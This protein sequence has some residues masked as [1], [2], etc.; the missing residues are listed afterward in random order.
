MKQKRPQQETPNHKF[1]VSS[2]SS[3]SRPC[4][5]FRQFC[6]KL[7]K[8]IIG[9]TFGLLK[10]PLRMTHC[11]WTHWLARWSPPQQIPLSWQIAFHSKFFLC[12]IGH[13]SLFSLITH[14]RNWGWKGL[15]WL[16]RNTVFARKRLLSEKKHPSNNELGGSVLLPQKLL[17]VF[18][19]T[20]TQTNAPSRPE[21]IRTCGT[22]YWTKKSNADSVKL[23]SKDRSRV[24][25][26]AGITQR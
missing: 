10:K 21:K 9:L 19:I 7:E 3:T 11:S 4:R 17:N 8:A 2:M 5:I 26:W 25:N 20:A 22:H 1:G 23:C 12:Q 6:R 13:Q 18:E 24:V 14:K 15:C 16:Q